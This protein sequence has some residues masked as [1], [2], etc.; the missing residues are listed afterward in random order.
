[1][2]ELSIIRKQEVGSRSQHNN[3]VN[4]RSILNSCTLHVHCYICTI[5]ATDINKSVT[6]K[7]ETCRGTTKVNE[8]NSMA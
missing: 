1:M 8:T 3:E 7:I 4:L 2:L 6:W 5:I